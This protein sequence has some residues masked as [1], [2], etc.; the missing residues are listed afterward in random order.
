MRTEVWRYVS[1]EDLEDYLCLGW[2]P[3]ALPDPHG[4]RLAMLLSM[5]RAA[6]PVRHA[7]SPTGSWRREPICLTEQPN[8]PSIYN[9]LS[10]LCH[11]QIGNHAD[12]CMPI[13]LCARVVGLGYARRKVIAA[14][15]VRMVLCPAHQSS[16]SAQAMVAPAVTRAPDVQNDLPEPGFWAR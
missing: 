1:W 10:T 13:L 14:C 8:D 12:G 16:L 5:H 3:I 9:H 6:W 7:R 11:C 2:L 4:L 15:S